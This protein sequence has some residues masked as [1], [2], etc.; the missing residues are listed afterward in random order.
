MLPDNYTRILIQILG[1]LIL[2]LKVLTSLK[3]F[4]G[5][6]LLALLNIIAIT[7]A[8]FIFLVY[9]LQQ[10]NLIYLIDN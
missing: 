3:S 2:Y 1:Y 4:V 10:K 7:L 5:S 9:N 8:A 6:S